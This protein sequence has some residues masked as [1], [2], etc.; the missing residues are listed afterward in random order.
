MKYL[1]KQI[2]T[3]GGIDGQTCVH[4]Q[5]SVMGSHENTCVKYTHLP[6]AYVTFRRQSSCQHMH[7]LG[8]TYEAVNGPQ[9]PA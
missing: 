2:C 9:L 7:H 1:L 8:L 3:F 6:Q 5:V 4:W